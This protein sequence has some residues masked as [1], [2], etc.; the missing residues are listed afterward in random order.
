M[1]THR[2]HSRRLITAVRSLF[3]GSRSNGTTARQATRPQLAPFLVR[4]L[5]ILQEQADGLLDRLREIGVQV[6][7]DKIS[8]DATDMLDRED[9][10][11]GG[12][13]DVVP[14]D[15]VRGFHAEAGTFPAPSMNPAEPSALDLLRR[16][17]RVRPL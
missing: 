4:E 10:P 8:W 5:D 3:K 7:A 6:R 15:G 14:D 1:E 13:G 16:A 17:I 9:Q 2:L 12:C 11:F